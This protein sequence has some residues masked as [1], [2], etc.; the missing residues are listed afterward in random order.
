[1]LVYDHVEVAQDASQC[2]R[3]CDKKSTRTSPHYSQSAAVF[4]SMAFVWSDSLVV[5]ASDAANS[6]HGRSEGN[7]G[8]PIPRRLIIRTDILDY[9]DGLSCV[10]CDLIPCQ[11]DIASQPTWQRLQVKPSL[12]VK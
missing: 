1:M 10:F 8:S 6:Q 7:E 5:D 3:I 2:V 9:G 11:R 4:L 12:Q